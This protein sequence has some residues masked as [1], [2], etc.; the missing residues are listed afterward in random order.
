MVLA[1]ALALV[2]AVASPVS[3]AKCAGVDTAII[4][5]SQS[6]KG[7]TAQDTGVWAL[8]VLALNILTAGVGITAVGGIVWASILYAS[9][10]DSA[11]Q[12]KRAKDIIKNIV[13]G[14]IAYAG[15]YILLNFLI[16]G[17]IFK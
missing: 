11:E 2:P 3:A 1:P 4:S 13:I 14:M 15:M 10:S 8:L 5:C 17:G 6:G 7:T 16:P 9:A 12:T